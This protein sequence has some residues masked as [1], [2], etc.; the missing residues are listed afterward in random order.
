MGEHDMEKSWIEWE[1]EQWRNGKRGPLPCD[2]P[3]VKP[4]LPA[5]ALMVFR[6]LKKLGCATAEQIANRCEDSVT[7]LEAAS[8]LSTL[9]SHGKVKKIGMTGRFEE[10]A[11]KWI[12]EVV[13]NERKG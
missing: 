12:Y 5:R 10:G 2:T 3:S 8:A 11:T 13:D 7:V 1:R 6:H 4:K 9:V